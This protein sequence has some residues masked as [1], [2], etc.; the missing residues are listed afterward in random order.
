[1]IQVYLPNINH[2][3]M[4]TLDCVLDPQ[5][6]GFSLQDSAGPWSLNMDEREVVTNESLEE[7]KTR[8]FK[9]AETIADSFAGSSLAWDNFSFQTSPN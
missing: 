9:T 6:F 4:G 7:R 3:R 1:M 8:Y 5:G 2:Y